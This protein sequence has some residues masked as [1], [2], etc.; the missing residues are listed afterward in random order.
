[1][2]DARL[3][4]SRSDRLIL[5]V[6]AGVAAYFNLGVTLVRVLWTALPPSPTASPPPSCPCVPNDA[7]QAQSPRDHTIPRALCQCS[8][9][10]S[11]K[12]MRMMSRCLYST[13]ST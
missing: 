4:R 1:M 3:Y 5:G 12:R 6:C 7:R 2:A 9:R 10:F 11:P 8:L 13:R